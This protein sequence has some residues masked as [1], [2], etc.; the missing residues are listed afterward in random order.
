MSTTPTAAYARRQREA[1]LHAAYLKRQ[2]WFKINRL[3]IAQLKALLP[4]VTG[5]QAAMVASRLASREKYRAA[6]HHKKAARIQAA[7]EA[8][9]DARLAR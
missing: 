3:T 5:E 8:E 4:T 7:A 9:Q 1:E 2:F 6:Q